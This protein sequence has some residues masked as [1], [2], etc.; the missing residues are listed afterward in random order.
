MSEQL[1]DLND[2]VSELK[3]TKSLTGLMMPPQTAN[4]VT[5]AEKIDENNIDDFIYRKSSIL[6]QQG[7]DTIEALKSSVLNQ[8]FSCISF[9]I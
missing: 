1:D 2:L 5:S 7:V 9:P 4:S 6:I 8:N 3:N